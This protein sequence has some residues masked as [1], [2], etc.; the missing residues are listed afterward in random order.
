MPISA[1][2]IFSYDQDMNPPF[3]N[4]E[5]YVGK[6]NAY[7][8]MIDKL[9]AYGSEIGLHGYNHQSLSL[10]STVTFKW[11]NQENM[12]ESLK[13]A[14]DDFK[15]FLGNDFKPFSYVA[16]MNVIDD[17]GIR[18]VLKV[19]PSVKVISTL[20]NK[21][22][23][24]YESI[25]D[26]GLIPGTDV[27][28]MPRTT[29]GYQLNDIFLY[30]FNFGIWNFGAWTHFIHL[31]DSYDAD[32]NKGILWNNLIKEFDT[33]IDYVKKNYPFLRYYT[34]RD[35]Y[36]VLMDYEQTGY[37]FYKNRS[38]KEIDVDVKSDNSRTDKF[39]SVKLPDG[40]RLKNIDNGEAVYVFPEREFIIIKTSGGLTKIFYD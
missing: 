17:T 5:Y 20:F 38:K 21:D 9:E 40:G 12:E 14:K 15:I 30:D 6:N 26:F 35:A 10:S 16:P 11:R 24:S 27:M 4:G 7:K 25:M 34:T 3:T 23:S 18:A 39:I 2:A 37:K 28:K 22:E 29:Y 31:D 8:R 13:V 19:F 1:Y 33:Q 32:R 36:R